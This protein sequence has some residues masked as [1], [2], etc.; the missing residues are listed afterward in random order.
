MD[1]LLQYL[2]PDTTGIVCEFLING[3]DYTPFTLEDIRQL[4]KRIYNWFHCM[5]WA[6]RVGNIPILKY[7]GKKKII[8]GIN[9]ERCAEEAAAHGNLE[10]FKYAASRAFYYGWAAWQI[11][12]FCATKKGHVHIARYASNHFSVRN[13]EEC[14]LEAA[15][16]GNIELVKYFETKCGQSK[17]ETLRK[18]TWKEC[19]W[20]AKEKHHLEVMDYCSEAIR[21]TAGC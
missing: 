3:D 1:I 8:T 2:D 10:G 20:A 5:Q 19:F 21:K 4:E 11:G 16:S 9:W 13:W 15:L 12:V 7:V 14:L 18:S 6:A 17:T